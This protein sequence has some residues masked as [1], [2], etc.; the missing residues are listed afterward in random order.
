LAQSTLAIDGGVPVRSTPWPAWPSFSAAEAKLVSD[1]VLSGRVNYWTGDFGKRFE[2]AYAEYL[3]VARAIAVM[4]GTVALELAL[5]GLGVG[6]GDEVVVPCRTFIASASAVVAVGATPVL[7][8][9]DRVTQNL[10]AEQVS[11][12]LTPATRAVIA[13]HLAGMPVDMD[14]LVRLCTDRKLMLV[15]DCAQAHG[16]YYRGKP[17]GS[18]GDAAAFSFCQDKI[19]TTGG[20]GGM[21]ATDDHQAADRMVRYKDHGKDPVLMAEAAGVNRFA[22]I[23][24]SFGT[25]LRMTEMQAALGLLQLERLADSV[26]QRRR[27]AEL[28]ASGLQGVAGVRVFPVPDWARHA[29]YKFY[30]FVD[31]ERLQLG[32]TRDRLVQAISAE[33]IYIGSGSCPDIGLER[34]FEDSP[35][36]AARRPEAAWLAG[37][38]LM[39]QVHPTLTAS[40]IADAVGAVSKVMAVATGRSGS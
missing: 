32:W 31:T 1:V 16:A 29:Y 12:V 10:S 37:R 36:A 14:P 18:F 38:S 17:V 8:D 13:V 19:V 15:E 28:L 2:T 27:N 39:F 6:A 7:C 30:A 34:A 5:R 24:S 23:H 20:E 33:G 40:D 3:G 11:A 25:N 4:N 22:Y 9:V 35:S 21:V 26:A